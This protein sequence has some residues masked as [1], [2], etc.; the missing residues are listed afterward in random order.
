MSNIEVDVSVL[1]RD[2]EYPKH[3]M[4]RVEQTQKE[5]SIEIFSKLNYLST[6]ISS[7]AIS[8]A[9]NEA[10]TKTHGVWLYGLASVGGGI[11]VVIAE[12]IMRSLL[13]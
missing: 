11:F 8:M 4:D 6:Q 13:K 10:S 7:H 5:T 9:K 3:G 12:V 2:V 1:K